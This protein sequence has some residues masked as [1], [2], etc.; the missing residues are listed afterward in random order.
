MQPKAKRRG[1]MSEAKKDE[2]DFERVVMCSFTE[3]ELKTL[4]NSVH[5]RAGR[6]LNKV[7]EV[8]RVDYV[9]YDGYVPTIEDIRKL[10]KGSDEHFYLQRKIQEYMST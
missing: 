4:L 8:S 6:L 10:Q 7:D 9:R 5:E 1:K 2:S 3:S